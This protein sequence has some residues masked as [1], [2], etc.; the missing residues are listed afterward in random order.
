MFFKQCHRD[1]IEQSHDKP[2]DG[3]PDVLQSEGGTPCD[4]ASLGFNMSELNI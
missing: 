3:I 2:K 4:C 1:V